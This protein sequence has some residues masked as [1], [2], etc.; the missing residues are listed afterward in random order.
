M[1]FFK[2]WEAWKVNECGPYASVAKAKPKWCPFSIKEGYYFTVAGLLSGVFFRFNW[3]SFHTH[4]G[5]RQE[6][7][8]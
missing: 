6:P 1:V 2:S 5:S 3:L 7:K 4:F 8:L